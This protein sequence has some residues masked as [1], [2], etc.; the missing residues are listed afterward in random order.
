MIGRRAALRTVSASLATLGMLVAV[1]APALAGTCALQA[2]VAGGSASEEPIGE[3]VLIEGF[4]FAAGS[5]T[6]EYEIDGAPHTSEA[7]TADGAGTFE[8]TVTPVAGDEGLWTVIATDGDCIAETSFLMIAGATPQPSPT[9]APTAAPSGLP[10]VAME[11]PA[12]VGSA[13]ATVPVLALVAL[14]AF[15]TALVARVRQVHRAE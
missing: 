3:T 8:T 10:N 2:T 5:V 6:I 13:G 12:V 14:V 9:P 4:G 11:A 7:V 1:A 15:G